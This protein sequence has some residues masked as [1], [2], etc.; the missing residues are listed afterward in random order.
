MSSATRRKKTILF[1]AANPEFSCQLRLDKEV[2][3]IEE[4]LKRSQS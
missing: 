3:E 2:R 4:G 1:L